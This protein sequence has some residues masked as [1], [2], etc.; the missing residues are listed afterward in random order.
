MEENP[1]I[2][3]FE[4]FSM[5]SFGVPLA[6][7]HPDSELGLVVCVIEAEDVSKMKKLLR[8]HLGSSTR[9]EGYPIYFDV[10]GKVALL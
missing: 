6:Q 10:A 1:W 4:G 2:L 9:W 7:Q 5:L 8:E 3:E